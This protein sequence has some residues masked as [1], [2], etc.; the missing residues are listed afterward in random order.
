M[1]EPAKQA[2]DL[3]IGEPELASGLDLAQSSG[4]KPGQDLVAVEFGSAHREALHEPL[5]P[6]DRTFL[7]GGESGHFYLGPIISAKVV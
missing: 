1:F 5:N 3:A 2:S 7:L 4:L 6:A